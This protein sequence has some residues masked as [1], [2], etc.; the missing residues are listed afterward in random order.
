MNLPAIEA[1]NDVFNDVDRS[2][3]GKIDSARRVKSRTWVRKIARI[4][5]ISLLTRIPQIARCSYSVSHES[6]GKNKGRMTIVNENSNH[7]LEC[8]I[9]FTELHHKQLWSPRSFEYIYWKWTNKR[10]F[11]HEIMWSLALSKTEN[12]RYNVWVNRFVTV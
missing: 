5:P 11:L 8:I 4:V 2:C 3:F 7:F 12:C 1:A 6:V 9:D 10:Y